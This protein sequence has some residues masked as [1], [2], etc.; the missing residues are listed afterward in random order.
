MAG[1][2]ARAGCRS[3]RAAAMRA[4]SAAGVE[5][6]EAARRSASVSDP[7]APGFDGGGGTGGIGGLDGDGGGSEGA[8]GPDGT[9]APDGDDA[10][11]EPAWEGGFCRG[12]GDE[13]DDGSVAMPTWY[14][15]ARPRPALAATQFLVL[16][17][18][19]DRTYNHRSSWRRREP[20]TC[21]PGPARGFSRG[22]WR[23]GSRAPRKDARR[24]PPA[25]VSAPARATGR[26]ASAG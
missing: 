5:G 24:R 3:G 22:R 1:L 15:R 21:T 23:A 17:N 7:A 10:L 19:A 12:D 18:P 14:G 25:A 2:V 16:S 13:G 6:E 9:D 26:G 8:A 20:R 11:G 4:S